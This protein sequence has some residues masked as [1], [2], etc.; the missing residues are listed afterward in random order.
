[1]GQMRPTG[2]WKTFALPGYSKNGQSFF[3]TPKPHSTDV[4]TRFITLLHRRQLGQPE[5]I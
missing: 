3:M 1:M 4:R 5:R 2:D